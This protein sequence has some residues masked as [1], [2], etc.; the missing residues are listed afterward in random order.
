M[1]TL[2]DIATDMVNQ[3]LRPGR[4]VRELPRGLEIPAVCAG[5]QWTLT[6]ARPA[7][8]PAEEEVASCRAAFG[9]PSDAAREDLDRTVTFRWPSTTVEDREARA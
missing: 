7:V 8:K 5:G 1:A 6:L 3:A 9:V 2:A 4:S